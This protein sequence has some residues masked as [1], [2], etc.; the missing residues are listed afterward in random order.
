MVVTYDEHGGFF[1]HVSPPTLRTDP[2]AGAPYK[3]GFE[4]LGVRV[5][6]FVISPFVTPKTV[7]N[8]VLDHTSILKFI[9]QKFGKGGRYSDLVD[10]RPVGSVLDVLN[11]SNPL[12]APPIPSLVP[13]LQKQPAI[14]GFTPGTVPTAPIP[15]GFQIALDHI[16][17]HPN[18]TNG[19]FD[20]LLAKFPP[21]PG[22][23]PS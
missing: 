15:Q 13:Y 22:I 19:K 8:Q 17:T 9:G 2:P 6:G 10:K 4:T 1:D 7:F 18:N 3:S 12:P 23:L 21:Q 20:E 5:P 16:R 14:A 11:N